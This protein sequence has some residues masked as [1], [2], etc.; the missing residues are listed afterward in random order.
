MSWRR[1]GRKWFKSWILKDPMEQN[2]YQNTG[3]ECT[4]GTEIMRSRQESSNELPAKA[5]TRTLS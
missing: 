1:R 4:G 5:D 2:R 3:S